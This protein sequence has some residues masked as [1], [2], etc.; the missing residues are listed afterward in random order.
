MTKMKDKVYKMALERAKHEG[1]H[2]DPRLL[3]PADAYYNDL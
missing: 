2:K 1:I 3:N